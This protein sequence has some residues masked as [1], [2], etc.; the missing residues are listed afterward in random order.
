[1]P[2][3]NIKNLLEWF[4]DL[5]K[6][7]LKPVQRQINLS[8]W[9]DGDPRAKA[10]RIIEVEGNIDYDPENDFWIQYARNSNKRGK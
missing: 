8:D 7:G 6:Q 3:E 5:E 9:S 2:S 4:D 1:M 10:N